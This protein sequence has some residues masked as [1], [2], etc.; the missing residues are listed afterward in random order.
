MFFSVMVRVCAVMCRAN[1]SGPA[2]LPAVPGVPEGEGRA[3]APMCGALGLL[4]MLLFF[5]F[6]VPKTISF[7]T[8]NCSRRSACLL[9]EGAVPG[10]AWLLPRRETVPTACHRKIGIP[11]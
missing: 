3:S 11:K 9:F 4:P 8:A 5:G 10:K 7:C 6:A 2:D 1:A